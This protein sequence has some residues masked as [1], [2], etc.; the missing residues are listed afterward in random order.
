[1]KT[2]E[3]T[4][5]DLNGKSR[6]GLI[7][8]LDIKQAREKMAATG[9]FTDTVRPAELVQ[10]EGVFARRNLFSRG[11]RAV[12]YRELSSLLGAG[13]PLTTALEVMI[14]SPDLVVTG[15]TIAGIRDKIREGC[16][17]TDAIVSQGT[18]IYPAETSFIAAG[19]KS[20][21]L[22]P[23][24]KN[25]A[26][27]M[28]EEA[29]MRQRIVTSLIY[30]G[31]IICL[32]LA[33][34]I[35]LLGFTVPR[36]TQV[37]SSEMN[38]SLPFLTRVII[39]LGKIFVKSAP[40]IFVAALAA[41]Y[42]VWR[43]ILRNQAYKIRLDQKLFAVPIIGKCYTTLS[44]LRFARTLALLLRGGVP[45]VESVNLAGQS[46]GSAS[47]LTQ[48]I[49]EAEA[50]RNGS[51]LSEAVARIVPL[52]PLLTGIIQIGE[53][54][55]SLEQVLKSAEERYQ[56]QWEQQVARIMAWFEP[57]L[58]L[59]VGCFVLLVVVSILLP[60]LALNRQLM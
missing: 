56:D 60:I 26:E 7:E 42:L 10:T 51:S 4:G 28:E 39:G 13:L 24:L 29:K 58:I 16:S 23:V 40:F 22:A 41:A 49:H 35:G 55:G 34:A 3:Y 46:T 50:I 59:G 47:I 9:I 43:F 32:A 6:Q 14:R 20:G 52:G 19:E 30:P 33:I 31:I 12:F 5:Y 25:L 17:L 21:E 8:A 45:L 15:T 44:A 18:G 37:L 54:S 27:F 1:M 36:V 57:A 38:I 53:N 48:S 11:K 2:F